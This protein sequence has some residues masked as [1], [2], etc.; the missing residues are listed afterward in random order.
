M[1]T[2][3]VLECEKCKHYESFHRYP[4]PNA[5]AR[6]YC[7]KCNDEIK[8]VRANMF[9][10]MYMVWLPKKCY[11]NNYFE[12]SEESKRERESRYIDYG[13]CQVE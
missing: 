5:V 4:N 3:Q 8:Y 11:L 9:S 10:D 1:T 13:F 7:N 2:Y 6:H 12:E